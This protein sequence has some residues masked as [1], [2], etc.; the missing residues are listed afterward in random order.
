MLPPSCVVWLFSLVLSSLFTWLL[1]PD[2]RPLLT[3]QPFQ[4]PRASSLRHGWTSGS[5]V[6]PH[7]L[8]WSRTALGSLTWPLAT[9]APSPS[10][11]WDRFLVI[12]SH[13]LV[14]QRRQIAG[15]H[16]ALSGGSLFINKCPLQHQ[17]EEGGG[18]RPEGEM[19]EERENVRWTHNTSDPL[20]FL[21]PPSAPLT[22]FFP[23]LKCKSFHPRAFAYAIFSVQNSP[24]ALLRYDSFP[25]FSVHLKWSRLSKAFLAT[26]H[27][28]DF[29]SHHS[30]CSS[31]HITI[32]NY[33]NCLFPCFLSLVP[34]RL[35]ASWVECLSAFPQCLASNKY[36]SVY[37]LLSLRVG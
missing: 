11:V 7:R 6:I 28:C 35:S 27:H 15:P 33:S 25:P 2:P 10:L 12:H 5:L 16:P 30:L 13:S 17:P 23:F 18:M 20:V 21:S 14:Y 1:Y 31:V 22:P 9:A 8:C 3:L 24:S 36:L 37:P 32:R 34:M 4:R 19:Q 29:P 26:L